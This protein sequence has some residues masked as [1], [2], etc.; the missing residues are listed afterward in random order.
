M[1]LTTG[2]FGGGGP[3][4]AMFAVV[5]VAM[6]P[7]AISGFFGILLSATQAALGFDTAAAGAVQLLSIVLGLSFWIWCVV[8]VVIGASKARGVGYG[9]LRARALSLAP[10]AR[11]L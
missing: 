11:R 9:R 7:L 4:K 3:L 8:L 1:Q 2:F 6:V 10:V 5:G